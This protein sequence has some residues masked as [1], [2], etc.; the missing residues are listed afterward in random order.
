MKSVVWSLDESLQFIRGLA[1]GARK[2]HYDLALG[3]GVLRNG[4][5]V[6]DLDVICC[7]ANW[8]PE[9]DTCKAK[10]FEDFLLWLKSIPG[11]RLQSENPDDG[12]GWNS[13]SRVFVFRD[14]A[15]RKIDFF[16]HFHPG[17]TTRF[18]HVRWPQ[19]Y[20]GSTP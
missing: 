17:R 6:N 5:S 11:L 20:E 19:P 14:S 10:D 1:H 3:G 4:Y 15:D 9:Y 13:L 12:F 7:P 8:Q 2:F 16:V 18:N